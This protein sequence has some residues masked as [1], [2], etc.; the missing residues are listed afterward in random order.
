VGEITPPGA[1]GDEPGISSSPVVCNKGPNPGEAPIRRLSN[2]EY[3]NV[4]A[5]LFGDTALA[6]NVSA[7]L[8]PVTTSLGFHNGAKFMQVSEVVAT[9]F[10]ESAEKVA[11]NV[12]IKP[13]TFP[14][15]ASEGKACATQAITELGLKIYRRPL[16]P[17]EVARYE[18]EY[19]EGSAD[20]GFEGGME[21]VIF[22]MLQSPY[23]LY[24]VEFGQDAAGKA[25]TRPTH[26]EMASRLSFLLWQ[27]LP[28]QVL[29][30]AAAAGEL[31]TKEQVAAQA[32]RM[33]KDPRAK[34]VSLFFEEWLDL[35]SVP[36]MQRDEELF[37]EWN[38]DLGKLFV[39]ETRQFVNHVLWEGD[40]SFVTLFTAPY[41]FLNAELASH[42]GVSGP[43][44]AEFVLTQMPGRA[45]LLTQAGVVSAHDRQTRT[46]IVM[47]G[48]KIRTDVLCQTIGAPPNDVIPELKELSANVT[49]KERLEEHRA[50]PACA[51]CH[52]LTDP[53]GVTFESFDAL[54]RSRTEDEWGVPV[55][56]QSELTHTEDA[57]GPMANAAELAG[58]LANSKEVRE[59]FTTQT[60][61]FFY[62]RGEAEQ[63]ACSQKQLNDAFAKSS[64]S[65]PELLVA[66]TQTD[67][68]LY[69]P[70]VV[71]GV[72]E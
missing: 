56:T 67:A 9:A 15:P 64:Y 38:S 37:P 58:L 22:A 7:S 52:D 54:G 68:F 26:Y 70:T 2:A 27:S 6:A 32:R 71:P 40:G 69:R 29:F 5:D 18:L 31:G 17:D 14:C 60:F 36:A 46:A 66:L 30:D 24:R 63:D 65:V 42:Y 57:N 61:R 53:I 21:W 23:F 20:G 49:Q 59:C 72:S 51:G 39:E 1:Q 3:Q 62:G 16:T 48:V 12:S 45:G 50:D 44:G 55:N 33:L 34:R 43:T 35:D 28:D 19:D 41:S 11:E 13:E 25:V 8:S 4:I 47:R 10:M